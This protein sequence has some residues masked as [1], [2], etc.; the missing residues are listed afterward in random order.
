MN[1]LHE[2]TQ[3]A[4]EQLLAGEAVEVVGSDFPDL[5]LLDDD[6]SLIDGADEALLGLMAS[7][8]LHSR[9]L[10]ELLDG[11]EPS[12]DDVEEWH[13]L[14]R[15]LLT[16]GALAAYLSGLGLD[17]D[18]ISGGMMDTLDEASVEWLSDFLDG[19]TLD[20]IPGEEAVTVEGQLTYA[21]GFFLAL[22]A[23][24]GIAGSVSGR[25]LVRDGRLTD[26][27]WRRGDSYANALWKVKQAGKSFREM[28]YHLPL[29]PGDG[30]PCGGGCRC[31]WNEIVLDADNDDVDAYWLTEGDD[32][33]CPVC[34]ARG[35]R[36][37]PLRIR[38]GRF[39]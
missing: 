7:H 33:V 39:V 25:P 36:F 6:N 17:I 1:E 11:D 5:R 27:A 15:E 21:E 26:A 30:S 20:D 32:R 13:E 37:N 8:V 22:L 14:F 19:T 3:A 9:D 31:R 28:G 12:R 38:G 16:F 24:F 35:G 23:G 10:L 2:Q 34:R 4:V 18:D 29:Y